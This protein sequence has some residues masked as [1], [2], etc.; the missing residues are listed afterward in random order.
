MAAHDFDR[1]AWIGTLERAVG[2]QGGGGELLL[3]SHGRPEQGRLLGVRS[4]PGR[5]QVRLEPAVEVV[6]DGDL[7]LLASL[8]PEPQDALVALVLEVA[9][10][11]TGQ[12]SHLS[13]RVGQHPQY[14]PI[15]QSH[16]MRSVVRGVV[17]HL[18]RGIKLNWSRVQAV[19]PRTRTTVMLYQDQAPRGRRK[20]KGLFHS[21][22]DDSLTLERQ[23]GQR[24]TFQKLAVRKV[25]VH[26]PLLKRYQGWIALGVSAF[27][28][29]GPEKR[30]TTINPK[31]RAEPMSPPK[32]T[33][34][35]RRVGLCCVHA[36]SAGTHRAGAMA[37]SGDVAR[38]LAT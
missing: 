1:T 24:H 2:R 28:G 14:G 3:L 19:K 21:A 11:Q 13:S 12:G 26:R 33:R 10:A 25:L 17:V 9:A 38:D 34:W 7:A 27:L 22:T 15:P 6:A 20:I 30:C 8:F 4:D 5:V 32:A 35:G 18:S 36:D 16:D 29:L 37:R 23:D 31:E